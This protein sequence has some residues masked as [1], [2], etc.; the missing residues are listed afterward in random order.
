[1]FLSIYITS[2]IMNNFVINV[3][4]SLQIKPVS[5]Q[6]LSR[7]HNPA[8]IKKHLSRS[9]AKPKNTLTSNLYT[10]RVSTTKSSTRARNLPLR[11]VPSERYFYDLST[12]NFY[13]Q[14]SKSP[15]I[16]GFSHTHFSTLDINT[17]HSAVGRCRSDFASTRLLGR[18]S[19]GQLFCSRRLFVPRQQGN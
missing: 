3:D 19:H 18:P 11:L 9:L 5:C 8:K 15:Y 12:S 7:S 17:T 1:M 4:F 16:L 14:I 10:R 13:S 6:H 2:L